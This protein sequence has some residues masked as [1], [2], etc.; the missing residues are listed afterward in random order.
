MVISIR[1]KSQQVKPIVESIGSVAREVPEYLT[2]EPNKFS[3]QLMV[4]PEVDQ[5]SWPIE[6]NLAEICDFL[7]HTT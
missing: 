3:G 1:E 2:F 5:I 7:D 6:I 4:M